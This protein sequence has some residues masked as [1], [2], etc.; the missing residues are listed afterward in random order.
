MGLDQV[1]LGLR[2]TVKNFEY[3]VEYRGLAFAR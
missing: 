2:D 1:R 3:D